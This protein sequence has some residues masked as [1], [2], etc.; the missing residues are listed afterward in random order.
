VRR[1]L[2]EI[3]AL[4]TGKPVEEVKNDTDRDYF[5]SSDEARDYGIIDRVISE[6]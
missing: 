2:D 4:H 5:M 3:I 1:R 6:H